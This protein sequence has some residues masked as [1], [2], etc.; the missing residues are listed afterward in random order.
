MGRGRVGRTK[1]RTDGFFPQSRERVKRG[2][3]EG[4][5]VSEDLKTHRRRT[6]SGFYKRPVSLK[7]R[8]Y[9]TMVQLFRGVLSRFST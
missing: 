1:R 3:V 7:E 5:E 6:L 9:L 8:K 4:V 2:E